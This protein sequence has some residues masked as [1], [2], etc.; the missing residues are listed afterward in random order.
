MKDVPVTYL[1][2]GDDENALRSTL[3]EFAANGVKNVVLC[4]LLISAIMKKYSFA[5]TIRKY[6]DLTGVKFVDSHAPFGPYIDMN[7][8]EPSRRR[9]MIL[10]QKLAL[11]IAASFG[12]DTMTIHIGNDAR[13]PEVPLERQT[14]LVCEALSE[15]LPEAEKCGITICI[16]NIWFRINTPDMLLKIKSHFPTPNLGFCYDAGHANLMTNGRAF[17]DGAASK[18]WGMFGETPDWDDPIL[19]KMLPH[20]VNC[21]LHDNDGFEDSHQ[22]CGKGSVDW[23]KVVSLLKTAPRL[24]NIQCES[25]STKHAFSVKEMIETTNAVLN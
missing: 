20:I 14:E 16:E 18:A 17:A 7:V 6:L 3:P 2:I 12:V 4:D 24:K 22:L 19:E 9:E 8:P 23:K 11:N 15:L 21:H 25:I 10:R 5:D 13:F 1:F